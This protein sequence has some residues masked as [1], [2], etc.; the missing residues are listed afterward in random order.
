M[1]ISFF[2]SFKEIHMLPYVLDWKMFTNN[3]HLI[4][5]MLSD[6]T[7]LIKVIIFIQ[8]FIYFNIS[9]YINNKFKFT[10]K[11]IFLN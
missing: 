11:R 10:I 3:V 1:W 9:Q 2:M 7:F 5:V 8:F 4:R 6:V